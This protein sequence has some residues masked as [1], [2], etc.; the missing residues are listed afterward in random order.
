[1]SH[2]G[3][4]LLGAALG[5][6]ALW[7]VPVA[8]QTP[9]AAL[10]T[11][12]GAPDL[13]GI[14]ENEVVTP[15]ERPKEFGAREFLTAE[16]R[17]AREQQRLKEVAENKGR[18]RRDASAERDVAGAYNAIWEG[19]PRTQVGKRTSQV[20]DPPDGRVPARTP[21]AEKRIKAYRDYQLALLQATDT[22]K[23][24][25]TACRDGQYVPTPS[26]RRNEMPPVYNIDRI[27]RA[28]GPEDNSSAVRCLTPFAGN[29]E[30]QLGTLQRIVQSPDA[31]AFYYDIGQGGGFSRV[32]PI[33]N[34]PHLP[35]NLRE[36]MGDA[37][38]HWEGDTLVVDITNFTRQ[39]DFRGS[40]ENLHLVERYRRLDAKT[41]EQK[42]TVEDPATWTKPWTAIVELAKQDEKANQ[43]YQQT[44]HEGNYGQTGILANMRA[45]ELAFAEGRGSDPAV[46]DN[47]SG[48]GGQD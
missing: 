8:G 36:W 43:I 28:D 20:I 39:T 2:R 33:T 32:V 45:A 44:C 19:V 21:D 4:A 30:P 14:W 15:F 6:I 9:A 11:P 18:D 26:A 24:K 31:V 40:R 34:A 13:Q 5:G 25:L 42:V 23:R 22:C 12:W 16:E 29:L 46:Q 47:A 38:A 3:L 27:N 48:G 10:R 1:M 7:L 17:A 37:R 41:L 35:G